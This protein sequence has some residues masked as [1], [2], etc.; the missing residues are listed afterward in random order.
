MLR[1]ENTSRG[2]SKNKKQTAIDPLKRYELML[3]LA[4]NRRERVR[5]PKRFGD[6]TGAG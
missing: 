2:I 5:A 4:S 6:A 1:Q 3:L